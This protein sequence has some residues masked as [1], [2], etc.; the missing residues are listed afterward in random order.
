MKWPY[1]T[2][3]A[4]I[5]LNIVQWIHSSNKIVSNEDVT[6]KIDSLQ[7]ANN[8]LRSQIETSTA[9]RDTAISIMLK[10]L[11]NINLVKQKFNAIREK[12]SATPVDSLFIRIKLRAVQPDSTGS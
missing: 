12:T 8:I 3:V 10:S 1:Y 9:E 11:N 5:I 7:S 6:K 2:I 4:L